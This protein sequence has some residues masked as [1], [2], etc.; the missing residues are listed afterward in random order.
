MRKTSIILC[1]VVLL[2]L[3]CEATHLVYVHNATLGVDVAVGTEGSA[4]VSIGYDRDTYSL[5]PRKGKG[6]DAMSVTSVSYIKVN[7][8]DD[9]VFDH[10]ISTGNAAKLL[11]KDPAGLRTIRRAIFDEPEGGQQ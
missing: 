2:F 11:A 6:E 3:G 8:L 1:L 10:F 9:V 5:V 4:K 7:G